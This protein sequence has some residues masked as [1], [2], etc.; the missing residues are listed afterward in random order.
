[1]AKANSEDGNKRL[2]LQRAILFF[3]L[4]FGIFILVT[5]N[6]YFFKKRNEYR[7][8]YEVYEVE[9]DILLRYIILPDTTKYDALDDF[10]K[11]SFLRDWV[12]S[13]VP[14]GGGG[15]HEYSSR[16]DLF[17]SFLRGNV[18]FACGGHGEILADVYQAFG[19]E[20]SSF[21]MG[22][23]SPH[24]HVVT[25]VKIQ[26]NEQTRI[27]VQDSFYGLTILDQ[28]GLPADIRSIL[29]AARQRDFTGLF[30]QMAVPDWKAKKEV[31]FSEQRINDYRTN[32]LKIYALDISK[33]EM[34]E[35][36]FSYFWFPIGV[37]AG[38]LYNEIHDIL[39]EFGRS[40][41]Y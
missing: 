9:S 6:L 12:S 11:T 35:S 15:Y 3:I 32:S 29:T 20:F 14:M 10:G 16:N 23:A 8:K 1:M 31:F 38:G 37:G 26:V 27:I 41:K 25:L 36:F 24:T 2:R 17:V 28:D 30:V 21:N 19:F 7:A 5:E 13:N 22:I 33:Y 4:I 40:T 39:A 34:P 18:G